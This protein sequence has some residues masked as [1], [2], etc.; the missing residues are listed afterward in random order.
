MYNKLIFLRNTV[1][2]LQKT[3]TRHKNNKLILVMHKSNN[4]NMLNVLMHTISI[5]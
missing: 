3:K 1:I 4:I 2:V 5:P